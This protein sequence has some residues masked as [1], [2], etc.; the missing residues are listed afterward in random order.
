M[1]EGGNYYAP[2]PEWEDDHE[3]CDECDDWIENHPCSVCCEPLESHFHMNE[4]E[5]VAQ[6]VRDE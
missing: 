2:D 6:A 3:R 4:A 1:T 5:S